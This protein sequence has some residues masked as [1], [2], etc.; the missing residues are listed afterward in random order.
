MYKVVKVVFA[1]TVNIDINNINN[2]MTIPTKCVSFCWWLNCCCYPCVWPGSEWRGFLNTSYAD[3]RQKISS[4]GRCVGMFTS[5]F[6]A[7]LSHYFC[8]LSQP[9]CSVPWYRGTIFPLCVDASHCPVL[10]AVLLQRFYPA[11]I[12]KF[13]VAKILLYRC[14]ETII[15]SCR[16]LIGGLDA[17]SY[18]TI[19]HVTCFLT[20]LRTSWR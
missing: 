3:I 10:Y 2:G 12:L 13:V 8:T 14:K 18:E 19:H 11:I 16:I 9:H 6:I 1:L 20:S 17:F 5:C 4:Q 15:A 7:V